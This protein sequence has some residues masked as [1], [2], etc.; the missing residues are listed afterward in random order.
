MKNFPA[1]VSG[2]GLALRKKR[3]NIRN[4]TGKVLAEETLLPGFYVIY[5]KS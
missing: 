1:T 4:V 5:Y 2:T 3:K